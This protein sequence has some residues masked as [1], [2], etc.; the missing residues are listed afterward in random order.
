MRMQ[1][2]QYFANSGSTAYFQPNIE[3]GNAVNG[4][5]A[6]GDVVGQWAQ[7]CAVAGS[8]EEGLHGSK[9]GSDRVTAG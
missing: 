6:F 3:H 1:I 9:G 4:D 8:Q 7:T 2:E 5:Q